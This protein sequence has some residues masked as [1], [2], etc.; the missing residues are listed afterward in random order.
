MASDGEVAGY[1][2]SSF[3]TSGVFWAL[4]V[5]GV[6]VAPVMFF[7]LGPEWLHTPSTGGLMWGTLVYSVG[8]IIPIGPF[9]SRYSSNSAGWSSSE[10]LRGR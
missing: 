5:A 3:E 1:D 6:L 9:S 10:R 2:L 4:R 8:V 7:K